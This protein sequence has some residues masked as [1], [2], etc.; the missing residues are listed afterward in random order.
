MARGGCRT[1]SSG[2]CKASSRR[3]GTQENAEHQLW[4]MQVSRKVAKLIFF[5]SWRLCVTLL[6]AGRAKNGRRTTADRERRVDAQSGVAPPPGK[7]AS[8]CFQRNVTERLVGVRSQRR[9]GGN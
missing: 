3:I 5:A 8:G 6:A 1:S 4:E 9:D 2:T 7:S